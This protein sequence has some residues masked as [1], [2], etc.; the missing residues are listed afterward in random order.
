MSYRLLFAPDGVHWV[1]HKDN[2]VPLE[3]LSESINEA[4]TFC[5]TNGFGKVKIINIRT[6]QVIWSSEE[7]V[8]NHPD[9]WIAQARTKK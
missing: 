4:R 3:K 5:M 2:N 1:N 6:K 9:C 8:K 7:E